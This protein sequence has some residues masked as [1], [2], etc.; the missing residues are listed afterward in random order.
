VV[1]CSKVGEHYTN[2]YW[3]K[4]HETNREDGRGGTTTLQ[5]I[6]EQYPV[7]TILRQNIQL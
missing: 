5:E 3:I 4:N 2:M 1:K 7:T 6:E